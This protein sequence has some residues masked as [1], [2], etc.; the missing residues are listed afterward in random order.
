[1]AA[2]RVVEGYARTVTGTPASKLS[3]SGCLAIALMTPIGWL[4]W[5]YA[6]MVL[7]GWFMVPFGLPPLSML[8][9]IGLGCVLGAFTPKWP[10]KT[11]PD[12]GDEAVMRTF[13]FS[14]VG[15]LFLLLIGW[16]AVSFGGAS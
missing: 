7:W 4:L 2:A 5:A 10:V 16:L 14:I 13:L 8:W 3:G 11:V 6:R 9:A 1:M 12:E 15:P